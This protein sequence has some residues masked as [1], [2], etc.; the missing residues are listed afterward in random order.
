MERQSFGLSAQI[1]GKT[2]LDE[3]AV[4][5]HIVGENNLDYFWLIPN[6]T[7]LWNIGI[8]FQKLPK[9]AVAQFWR[10]KA[11][12]VDTAFSQI[13]FMRPLKG[14]FCGHV[15]LSAQFPE[16]CYTVGDAAGQSLATTGEGL[17]YAITSAAAMAAQICEEDI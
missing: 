16:G 2:F 8:W 15:N 3:D 6:G 9:D 4:F 14:A 5:F 17:R 7:G 10:Y 11:D 12:F 13:D 1:A